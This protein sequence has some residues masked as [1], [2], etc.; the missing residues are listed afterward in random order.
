MPF[1]RQSSGKMDTGPDWSVDNFSA[2]DNSSEN[3]TW[4][5]GEEADSEIV[6]LY[7]YCH[8]KYSFY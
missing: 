7:R 6:N 3:L 2:S 8:F 5:C 4:I 1:F